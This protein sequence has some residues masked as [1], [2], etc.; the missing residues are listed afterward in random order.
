MLKGGKIFS[1]RGLRLSTKRSAFC[2][3]PTYIQHRD[4]IFKCLAL[5]VI[6][7]NLKAKYLQL[8]VKW[9]LTNGVNRID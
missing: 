9:F 3:K 6:F 1:T 8:S 4:L 5:F 2:V 7:R